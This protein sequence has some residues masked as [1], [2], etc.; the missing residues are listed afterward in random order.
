MRNL[1]DAEAARSR[2]WR[3]V[4]FLVCQRMRFQMLLHPRT[5]P[6]INNTRL[7]DYSVNTA[8]DTSPSDR[9]IIGRTTAV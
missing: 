4:S 7:E 2:R 1:I 3:V 8:S 9:R 6:T 5:L